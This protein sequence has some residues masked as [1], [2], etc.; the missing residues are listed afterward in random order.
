M[1]LQ[2]F[3][4]FLDDSRC[5]FELIPGQYQLLSCHH[6]AGLNKSDLDFQLRRGILESAANAMCNFILSVF[7]ARYLTSDSMFIKISCHGNDVDW[8]VL[9]SRPIKRGFEDVR[10]SLK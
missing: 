3:H 6:P 2:I 4:V 1:Y 7:L 9:C 8:E 10:A 5:V